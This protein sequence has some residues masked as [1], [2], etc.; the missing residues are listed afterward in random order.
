MEHGGCQV[1]ESFK[2]LLLLN[3]LTSFLFLDSQLWNYSDTD[4]ILE[5]KKDS[6][7]YGNKAWTMP[8]EDGEGYIVDV[9]N[10]LSV[11]G[12]G[13]SIKF[14]PLTLNSNLHLGSSFARIK[15][16]HLNEA[17]LQPKTISSDDTQTW[18]RGKRNSKGYFTLQ[19]KADGKLLTFA[20][21]SKTILAG[22]IFFYILNI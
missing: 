1:R 16:K 21:S 12:L 17:E 9:E 22:T 7:M 6:W 4:M 3:I 10:N 8:K 20:T 2:S 15:L 18:I 14:K 13:K 5:N 11:L 19:N